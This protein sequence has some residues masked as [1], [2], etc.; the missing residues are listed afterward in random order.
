MIIGNNG[1]YP[2]FLRVLRNKCHM[3]GKKIGENF[4]WKYFK[5]VLQ[6]NWCLRTTLT[7]APIAYLI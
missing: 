6:C 3:I 2:I 1:M 4:C 7:C 5:N